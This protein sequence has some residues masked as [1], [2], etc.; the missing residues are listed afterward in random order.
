MGR[1]LYLCNG[2]KECGKKSNLSCGVCSYDKFNDCQ[3]FH[4]TDKEYALNG[5]VAND[6]ELY[7]GRFDIINDFYMERM[8]YAK[9]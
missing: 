2:K 4:T 7:S 9:D 8:S 1:I 3:C 5:A 6:S